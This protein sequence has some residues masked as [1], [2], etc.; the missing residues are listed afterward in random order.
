MFSLRGYVAQILVHICG[1]M[2]HFVGNLMPVGPHN[3]RRKLKLVH[4]RLRFPKP[5]NLS[6][7]YGFEFVLPTGSR[8]GLSSSDPALRMYPVSSVHSVV[9]DTLCKSYHKEIRVDAMVSSPTI[10]QTPGWAPGENA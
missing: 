2:G 7:F 4:D 1:F 6:A 8:F 10:L 9:D 5:K 3:E